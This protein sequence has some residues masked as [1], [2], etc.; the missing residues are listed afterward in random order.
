MSKRSST[1]T[2]S[3]PIIRSK[4]LSD[5]LSIKVLMPMNVQQQSAVFKKHIMP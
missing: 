5:D 3:N 4:K 1:A 2:S